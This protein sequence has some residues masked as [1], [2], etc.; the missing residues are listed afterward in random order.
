MCG[1]PRLITFALDYDEALICFQVDVGL[2]PP[3]ENVPLPLRQRGLLK[4]SKSLG[5]YARI[6]SCQCLALLTRR[7][8][9]VT[10][11]DIW[12]WID[13]QIPEQLPWRIELRFTEGAVAAVPV[14]A[15]QIAAVIRNARLSTAKARQA[16]QP[17]NPTSAG[18]VRRE[19]LIEHWRDARER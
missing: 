16:K 9:H 15:P 3:L 11:S 2:T 14:V 4:E 13:Y 1:R 18:S 6:A 12:W 17:R 10:L 19:E 5:R 7:D 8:R